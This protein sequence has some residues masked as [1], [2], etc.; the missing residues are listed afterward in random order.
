MNQIQSVLNRYAGGH[1]LTNLC[2]QLYQENVNNIVKIKVE[3]VRRKP[4]FSLEETDI[5]CKTMDDQIL[6]EYRSKVV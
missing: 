2:Y 1:S 4:T 5:I 3:K 6:G